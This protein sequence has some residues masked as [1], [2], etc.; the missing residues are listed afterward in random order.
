[1]NIILR[2]YHLFKN[3]TTDEKVEMIMREPMRKLEKTNQ[4]IIKV[5][6]LMCSESVT[7]KIAKAVG[8]L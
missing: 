4:T 5:N 3:G 2:I 1:M 8:A 6:R 7:Y